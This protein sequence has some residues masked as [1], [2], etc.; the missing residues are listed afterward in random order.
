VKAMWSWPSYDTNSV[1]VQDNELAGDVLNYL[2]EIP[3]KPLL[4]NAYQERYMPGSTFKVIT[5]AAALD[6]GLITKESTWVDEN[7]F[8]PPQTTDPIQNYGNKICGGDLPEVFRRSCNTPFAR[9]AIEL[10]PEKMVAAAERFG[11][12][13]EIPFDL[14]RSASSQFGDVEY[15][16]QNLPLL[17]IGG[18]GQGNTQMVPLHMAMVAASIAHGGVMMKPFVVGATYDHDGGVLQRTAPTVWKTPMT[19]STASLLTELMVGVVN[20]GTASC[21]M[22]LANGVQAAAKTG[23]AQLNATGEPERSHAWIIA[24]APAEA[25]KYA[26]VVML[27]GTTAEISEGTGGTLAGPVAKKVLDI[28]LAQ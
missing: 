16:T 18:F 11:I 4:A 14:P 6:D 3:G 21:C 20:E 24:F 12:G 9:T 5:T 22:S 17:G 23:T 8:L 1:A 27:K 13:Q 28:A 26:I 15:F 7:E 25:P 10:G 19:P 2:G